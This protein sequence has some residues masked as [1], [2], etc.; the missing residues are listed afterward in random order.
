[1]KS[2]RPRFQFF[3]VPALRALGNKRASSRDCGKLASGLR[4][5]GRAAA[6]ANADGLRSLTV[7]FTLI[8]LLV[9]IAIIAILAAIML[10][11]LNSAKIR[12]QEAECINNLK[13]LELG[14]YTY[15]QDNADF[16]LPNAPLGG[17]TAQT[18]CGG[19]EESISTAADA[20]TNIALYD[21][22]IM[23]PYMS[24][25]IQAY[26]CPGDTV[27][28]PNGVRL[29][30][31]S[32][33]GQMG[34]L[35]SFVQGVCKQENPN[36]L[37][38]IKYNDLAGKLSPSDAFIFC[39]ENGC[40]I[41]DGWLEMDCSTYTYPDIPA[42]YHQKACGF[43]FADGHAEM[44][45]WLRGDLPGKPMQE[46]FQNLTYH[47]QQATGAKYDVDWNW[48]IQHTSIPGNNN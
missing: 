36:F 31:Y 10:P 43:A 14:A 45:K 1:M 18:W 33:N 30:S 5:P 7:A 20:N 19:E 41:N 12:A 21:N 13:E 37:Y 16:M 22:S 6:S 34:A 17:P 32:M 15:A 48:L 42:A 44:H 2:N 39:D 8:E 35:Y 27:P 3:G 29:R 24:S 11:V 25:Q 38:F 9:V 28:S 47:T 4:P 26:R 23:G 40:S 46:Y